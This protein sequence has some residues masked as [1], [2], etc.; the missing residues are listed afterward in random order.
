MSL[1]ANVLLGL[2]TT[3]PQHGYELKR[4]YDARLPRARPLAFGQVYGTLGRLQRDGLV[5]E[6]GRDREG[7]PDR[8]LFDI[9]DA[10]R[11]VLGDW[12]DTVEPPAPHVSSALLAKVVVALIADGDERARGY[13]TAQRAAHTARLRELTALKTAPGAS[14]GDVIA[15]DL[16]IVHLDAD[17][18][19]LRTTLDRVAE[20]H[21]EVR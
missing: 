14:L 6:A 20:L 21:R 16:A 11:A 7:G 13:L 10:G 3:G 2:L 19:W 9:T 1:A 15:A 5:A 8:T 17:L 12:L 4:A 18:R